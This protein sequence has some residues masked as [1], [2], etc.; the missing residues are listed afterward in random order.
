MDEQLSQDKYVDFIHD[1]D[2]A[3]NNAV[4]YVKQTPNGYH[5]VVSHG[6]DTRDLYN[7]YPNLE[8]KRCFV[9]SRFTLF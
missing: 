3:S 8:V 9:I 6:F 5:V 2:L 4:E 7:K 1:V